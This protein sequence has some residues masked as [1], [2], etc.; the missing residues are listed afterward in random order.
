MDAQDVIILIIGTPKKGALINGNPKSYKPASQFPF[1]LAFF[2][3]LI[4]PVRGNL[5]LFN[6]K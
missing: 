4:S 2:F 1:H 5:H 3:H 6:P